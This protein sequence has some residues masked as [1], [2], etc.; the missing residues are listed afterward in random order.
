MDSVNKKEQ[1][2]YVKGMI[3]KCSLKQHQCSVTEFC[4]KKINLKNQMLRQVS[5]YYTLLTVLHCRSNYK[6]QHTQSGILT[7]VDDQPIR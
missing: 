7:E 1:C 5:L 4:I 3:N 6:L 2:D